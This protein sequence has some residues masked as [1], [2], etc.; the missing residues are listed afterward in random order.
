N[1]GYFDDAGAKAIGKYYLIS[2]DKRLEETTTTD[3]LENGGEIITSTSYCYSTEHHMPTCISTIC[4]DLQ[5]TEYTV[6]RVII[7][8]HIYI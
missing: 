3:Y 7:L 5:Q 2:G 6:Y 8:N 1:T 4:G